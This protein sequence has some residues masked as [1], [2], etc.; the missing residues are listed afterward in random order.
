M[1][2]GLILLFVLAAF[3]AYFFAR[4]RRRMGLGVTGRTW[5]TVMI[6]FVLLMLALWA[7]ATQR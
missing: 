1:T 3:V 6:G 7:G 2:N 4:A 5:V